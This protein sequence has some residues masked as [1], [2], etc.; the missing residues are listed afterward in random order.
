MGIIF[1]SI[2]NE[3]ISHEHSFQE[4]ICDATLSHPRKLE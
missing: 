2:N 1:S 3:T 4:E